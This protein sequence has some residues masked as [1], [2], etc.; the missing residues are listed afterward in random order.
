VIAQ[1]NPP[2]PLATAEG[3]GWVHFVI[4]Y[5]PESAL[6]VIAARDQPLPG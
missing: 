5:G 4:D 6:R 2:L 3:A 1:L